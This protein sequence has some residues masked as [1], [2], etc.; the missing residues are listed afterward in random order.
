MRI[1]HDRGIT[2]TEAAK[3][4]D[5]KEEKTKRL[6][7]WIQSYGENYE[8]FLPDDLKDLNHELRMSGAIKDNASIYRAQLFPGKDPSEYTF[9]DWYGKP[10]NTTLSKIQNAVESKLGKTDQDRI[11]KIRSKIY[12]LEKERGTISEDVYDVAKRTPEQWKRINQ[13][14]QEAEDL[15]ADIRRVR[16]SFVTESADGYEIYKGLSREL[17]GDKA[18][19]LFL[20]RAGIDGIRY[21]TETLSGKGTKGGGA[22]NYVV[23][24]DKDVRMVSRESGGITVDLLKQK[25][26]DEIER[27]LLE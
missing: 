8:R 22:F 9:L 5:S 24:D 6:A 27:M 16:G 15:Y 17:G 3:I 23:F 10:N 25:E 18:A 1:A 11:N 20:K 14:D 7:D 12:A 4:F 19:S 21:P 26:V 2:I 13:I